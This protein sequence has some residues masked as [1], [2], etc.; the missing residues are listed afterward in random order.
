[1]T[2]TKKETA[3][4]A[5]DL[6]VGLSGA[7]VPEFDAARLLGNAAILAV[8]LRGLG[9]V[10]YRTLRLVAAH[11]FTIRSEAIDGVLNALAELELVRLI[12]TGGT[13]RSVIPEIPHFEDVYEQIG[14]YVDQR[15]LNEIEA[16]TIDILSRLFE[17]PI[18]K[19]ALRSALGIDATAFSTTLDIGATS[20]LIIGQRARGRDILASPLYFSGNLDGLIDIAA[21]GDTPSLHKL[22][23]LV[24]RNQGM[25]M[26]MIVSQSRIAETTISVDELQLLNSLAEEGIIKPPS[27][28]RPNQTEERFVFTP[29]PGKTR[30]SAANREIY[31]KAMALAAAV[32]KGQLLPEAIRI[33]SPQALLNA[34]EDRKRLRANTEAAHQYRN[35]TT[36]GVGRL[37]PS[38]SGY[39]TFH[40]IDVPENLQAVGIARQLLRG[41]APED[42]EQDTQ[43]RLLLNEDESYVR[44]HLASSSLRKA[45]QKSV[46]SAKA[47][48]EIDQYMLQ[49]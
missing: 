24:R 23:T 20:G 7:D 35:L 38:G 32:R 49:L 42:L 45:T 3:E 36:L 13:I 9:E 37:S 47:R 46:L 43:A 34:L 2:L 1:M 44:S 41:E 14:T 33:R 17:N 28:K 21:R 39:Y 27:I 8:N 31:E 25:P 11:Y 6:Q 19:D 40:L 29:A 16:I 4:Y 30:L 48:A 22:L 26:S 15:P 10:D 18:N 12:T 5:F